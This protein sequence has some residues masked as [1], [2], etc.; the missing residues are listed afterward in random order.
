MKGQ[1]L[2]LAGI[3]GL[4]SP[5]FIYLLLQTN[6]FVLIAVVCILISMVIYCEVKKM[7]Q[8]EAEHHDILRENEKVQIWDVYIDK[9]GMLKREPRK[10][11]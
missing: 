6:L 9:T 1:N 3:I 8:T 2:F 7:R 5:V 10:N 11:G 4:V